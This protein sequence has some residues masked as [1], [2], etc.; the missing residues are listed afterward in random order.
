M[1]FR[2]FEKQVHFECRYIQLSFLQM[3]R[4]NDCP[5]DTDSKIASLIVS[6]Q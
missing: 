2:A 6:M 1:S 4:G 3:D 5:T